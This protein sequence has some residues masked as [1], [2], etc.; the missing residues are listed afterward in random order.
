MKKLLLLTL[1]ALALI[2]SASAQF[3]AGTDF[4]AD[5]AE[6]QVGFT[7]TDDT[8]SVTAAGTDAI[9]NSFSLYFDTAV[10]MSALSTSNSASLQFAANAGHSAN[11]SFSISLFDAGFSSSYD[12]A[13]FNFSDSSLVGTG[14]NAGVDLSAIQ[15]MTITTGG[16]TGSS[17][18][19]DVSSFTVVPEPS[20]YA[21]I[22]G[23]AAF[24]FVAIRRRK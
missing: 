2:S 5:L 4:A 3:L 10:D 23:F 14:S 15:G 9:G 7:L 11:S 22:A 16:L 1:T 6:Y 17:V 21:L 19:V 20:T 18:N 24:L 12:L 8:N 13:G